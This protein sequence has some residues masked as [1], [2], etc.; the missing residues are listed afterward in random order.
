MNKKLFFDTIRFSLFG[1]LTVNQVEGIEAILDA[2]EEFKVTDLRQ[3]ASILAT[4]MIETGGS[5]IPLTENLN[6]SVEA[7]RAKFPNRIGAAQANQYGRKAGQSANQKMIANIIYGGD[8]GWANLG[9]TAPEDGWN[10][11]GRG[12][13]QITGRRNYTKLG[14]LLGIDLVSNPDEAGELQTA[15]RILVVASRDGLFTTKKLS[16]YFNDKVTDWRNARRIVNGLD[17]ADD[18][19]KWSI[20]FHDALKKAA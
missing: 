17:R 6:Y 19:A 11:R 8:W 20:Q 15:A 16:D 5:Y 12:L 3:I 4:P 14:K 13:A 2:C 18:L 9:N 7:L 10:M 1:S